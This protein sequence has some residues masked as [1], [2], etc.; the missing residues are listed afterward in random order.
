MSKQLTPVMQRTLLTIHQLRI[1]KGYMP[2]LREVADNLNYSPSAVQY[3]VDKLVELGYL[4]TLPAATWR[5]T[6]RAMR[7]TRSVLFQDQAIP[8]LGV[9]N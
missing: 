5:S 7:F 4:S 9:C 8:V 1:K 3:Q 6:S 2:T